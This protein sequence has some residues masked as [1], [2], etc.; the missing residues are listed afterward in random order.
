MSLTE[1]ELDVAFA[2][3]VSS[4]TEFYIWLLK[5]TKFASV[6]DSAILLDQE[7]ALAKPK[8]KPENWW[9]H[10]WCRLD[11]DSESETDIFLVFGLPGSDK[12]IALHIEDKPPHGKFTPN[13]YI[14]YNRR[15]EFMMNKLQYMNYQEFATILLAPACFINENQ[16][17]VS[18]FDCLILYESVAHRIPEFAQSLREAS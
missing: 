13:Q 7:Q 16:D 1:Y 8:K 14:N 9:R 6:A 12:R 4:S 2:R 18:H 17:Q 5:Q 11:D 15:A 3:E 10:W